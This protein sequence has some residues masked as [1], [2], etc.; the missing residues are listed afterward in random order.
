MGSMIQ[1]YGAPQAMRY[2]ALR[3]TSIMRSSS[4]RISLHKRG[5]V[6]GKRSFGAGRE[7]AQTSEIGYHP[8]RRGGFGTRYMHPPLFS[9]VTD[10]SSQR[11]LGQRVRVVSHVT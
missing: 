11:R 2:L 9:P 3:Q 4:D 7:Y 1:T 6:L 10:V 8:S 5:M